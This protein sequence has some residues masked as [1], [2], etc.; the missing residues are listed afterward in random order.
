[1]CMQFYTYIYVY[2]YIYIYI[3][4]MCL[5]CVFP[6]AANILGTNVLGLV[7]PKSSTS[8]VVYTREAP[9]SYKYKLWG[10]Y[11]QPYKWVTGFF[12]PLQ[13]EL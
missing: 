1:M 6:Y 7:I 4:T 13:V 3:C 10:P 11:K 9:I 8:S 2:V 12:S 5:L